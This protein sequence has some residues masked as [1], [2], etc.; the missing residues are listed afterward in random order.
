MVSGS[1]HTP[2][3]SPA[4]V[5]ENRQLWAQRRCP[6]QPGAR[7]TGSQLPA[8]CPANPRLL[9]AVSL[10]LG[11]LPLALP[12]Y[13]FPCDKWTFTY[14]LSISPTPGY[15]FQVSRAYICFILSVF[16]ALRTEPGM[17]EAPHQHLLSE[18]E[19]E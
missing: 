11:P 13:C 14:F 4:L 8:L 7:S 10:T 18:S 2:R 15:E 3:T 17:Q 1:L 5:D 12:C 16:S 9:C 19:N 6:S